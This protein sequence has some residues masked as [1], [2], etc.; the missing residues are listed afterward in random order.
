MEMFDGF[1]KMVKKTKMM[2]GPH[3]RWLVGTTSGE[4]D[5]GDEYAWMDMM[6]VGNQEGLG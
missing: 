3:L 5:E 6:N 1:Q 2:H 4:P